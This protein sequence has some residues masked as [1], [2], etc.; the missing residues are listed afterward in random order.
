MGPFRPSSLPVTETD[1]RPPT[2]SPILREGLASPS[3][4]RYPSSPA[5]RSSAPKRVSFGSFLIASSTPS[6]TLLTASSPNLC[7]ILSTRASKPTTNPSN[8]LFMDHFQLSSLFHSFSRDYWGSCC[9]SEPGRSSSFNSLS[10]DHTGPCRARGETPLGTF[11]SLSRDHL[12]EMQH[13]IQDALSMT[14]FQ[15][16]LSGSRQLG[17]RRQMTQIRTTRLSTPSL[18]ITEPDSGIFLLSAAF[19]RG[20]PSHKRFLKATIWIYRFALL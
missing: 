11:N 15:L 9:G 6:S 2:S 14:N 13:V 5:T 20:A 10:R 1:L 3:E 18:G 19:C 7:L 4:R 8:F 17:I 16:P 12:D